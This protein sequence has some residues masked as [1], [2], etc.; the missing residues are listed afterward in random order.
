M[1][2]HVHVVLIGDRYVGKTTLLSSAQYGRFEE[3]VVP[4]L[5]TGS[6]PPAFLREPTKVTVT[7]TSLRCQEEEE[8]CRII[9]SAD[10][11]CIVFAADDED[12]MIRI[13]TYWMQLVTKA[14]P[15][16]ATT[17]IVII[18][19][20]ID[21]ISEQ[22]Q[23]ERLLEQHILPL[24]TFYDRVEMCIECSAKTMENIAEVFHVTNKAVIYPIAPLYDARHHRLQPAA[25][26]ALTRVFKLCDEDKDDLLCDEELQAFQKSL[27]NA[28]LSREELHS[29]KS[30]VSNATRDGV[31]DNSITLTG[32]LYIQKLFIERGR[33]EATWTVLWAFGYNDNLRLDTDVLV[34]GLKLEVDCI[35]EI[36]PVGFDFLARLFHQHDFNRQ[37]TL[38]QEQ[39][40]QMFSIC[41]S[42]PWED[43]IYPSSAEYTWSL[44]QFLSLWVYLCWSRPDEFMR[45]LVYLGFVHTT[46]TGDKRVDVSAAISLSSTRHEERLLGTSTRKTYIAFIFGKQ[47]AGKTTFLKALSRT[48][49]QYVLGYQLRNR[50]GVGVHTLNGERHFLIAREYSLNTEDREI[51][52]SSF[53][54]D[55][56]D[57]IGLCYDVT[58][59]TSSVYA[60]SLKDFVVKPG[61]RVVILA[62]KADELT[63]IPHSVFQHDD[64]RAEQNAPIVKVSSIKGNV[65]E[66]AAVLIKE[67]SNPFL[68]ESLRNSIPR[69]SSSWLPVVGTMIGFVLVGYMI[70]RYRVRS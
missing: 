24:M 51:I 29:V 15:V 55:T 46:L 53:C 65:D 69:W 14:L 47:Q 26:A 28:P 32:F 7:D 54:A 18:G 30:V 8:I 66:A 23:H 27:F 56:C 67:A 37:G 25:I 35:V 34:P 61:P 64:V 31:S 11:L 1:R 42:I 5:E 17:P 13:Q 45:M 44:D 43:E 70:Y 48:G 22:S 59:T 52:S 63:H 20:K 60:T 39:L 49:S 38:S 57:V 10:V 50:T 58:D 19:N 16:N 62:C 40:N 41:P 21:L 36:S 9:S 33:I 6:L 4:L 12:S 68:A 2:D 3:N